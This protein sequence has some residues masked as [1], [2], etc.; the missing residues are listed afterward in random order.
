MF[1]VPSTPPGHPLAGLGGTKNS[2]ASKFVM[3]VDD[4]GAVVKLITEQKQSAIA[5][6]QRLQRLD[7]ALV[8]MGEQPEQ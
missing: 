5:A 1:R 6:K 7:Q 8:A 3:L 2:P 4:P